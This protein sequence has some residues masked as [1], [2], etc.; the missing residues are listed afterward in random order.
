MNASPYTA[1][2]KK[3]IIVRILKEYSSTEALAKEKTNRYYEILKVSEEATLAEIKK[4][5]RKL[6]LANHSDKMG[7]DSNLFTPISKAYEVLGDEVGKKK[8]DLCLSTD[9]EG[10]YINRKK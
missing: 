9:E 10:I 1:E 6:S 7:G 4:S 2:N 3:D 8:Y 5:Y